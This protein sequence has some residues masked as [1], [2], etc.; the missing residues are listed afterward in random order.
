[1]NRVIFS[2]WAGKVVDNR[3]LDTE[4]YTRV[5]GLELP[6][7]YNSHR[8]RAFIS[9]NGI[10]VTDSKV[11]IIDV[12]HSYLEEVQKLCCGECTV[13]YAG[14]KVMLDI[15]TGIL[16][17]AGEEGDIELLQWLG[18]GIKENAKSYF[19][20]TAVTHILDTIDY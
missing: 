12:A 13:G 7:E 15:M 9:W 14:I 2:S 19:C 4:K 6:L 18:T 20:A 17:G 11:N 1:M 16:H 8:I 3:G 10:V 5:A